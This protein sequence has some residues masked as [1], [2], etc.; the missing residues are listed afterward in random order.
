MSNVNDYTEQGGEATVIGGTLEIAPGGKLTIDAAA[1]VEG[2]VSAPVVDAL[3]STSV[4]FGKTFPSAPKVVIT[5][6]TSTSGVIS[7][8]I[9]SVTTTGFQATIGGSGFSNI[10]CDWIAILV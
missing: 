9:R 5:P 10:D 4:S 8:K 6:N 2:V 3:D 7:P 1:T